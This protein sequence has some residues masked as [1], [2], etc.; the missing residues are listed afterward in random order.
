MLDPRFFLTLSRRGTTLVR[1]LA[2]PVRIS[3]NNG[4][5]DMIASEKVFTDVLAM[6]F[7]T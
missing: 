2:L 1:H 5:I 6:H 4:L 7:N 3:S